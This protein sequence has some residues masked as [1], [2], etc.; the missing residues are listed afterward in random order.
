MALERVKDAENSR[1]LQPHTMPNAIYLNQQQ[2]IVL[3]YLNT[4]THQNTQ[5]P[6][7]SGVEHL[8]QPWPWPRIREVEA[9]NLLSLSGRIEG[10]K[11]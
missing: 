10:L 11:Q 4:R 7:I 6:L 5:Q 2:T 9:L 3:V 8:D 1:C